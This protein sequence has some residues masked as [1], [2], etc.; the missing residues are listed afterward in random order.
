MTG[1]WTQPADGLEREGLAGLCKG[2]GKGV[3][4]L[5]L[6]P[7]AGEKLFIL[8]NRGPDSSLSGVWGLPG[9]AFEGI[10]KQVQRL[11]TTTIKHQIVVALKLQGIEE[12]KEAGN[13]EKRVIIDRWA[14]PEIEVL[15]K[16][17]G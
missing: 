1:L 14:S 12:F 9:F 5:V 6:K 16:R 3:A 4:G 10:D 17:L 15:K 2:L 11:F 7:V 13:D 8:R